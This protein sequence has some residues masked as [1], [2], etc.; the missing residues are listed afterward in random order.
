MPEGPGVIR[1]GGSGHGV[2]EAMDGGSLMPEGRRG[3]IREGGREWAR[4]G[5]DERETEGGRGT[6]MEE[7]N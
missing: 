1:E 5:N 7:G 3:V 6:G 2:G 4:W